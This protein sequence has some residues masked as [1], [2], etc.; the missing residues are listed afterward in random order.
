MTKR[1]EIF[2]D[3]FT[4]RKVKGPTS[5]QTPLSIFVKKLQESL[6]RMETFDVVTVAQGIDGQLYVHRFAVA[7]VKA[8]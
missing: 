2:L 5:T 6:T 3:A 7:G 8:N 1:Q 4:L